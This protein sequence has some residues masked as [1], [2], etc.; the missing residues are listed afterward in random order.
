MAFFAS[1]TGMQ[2]EYHSAVPGD[3]SREYDMS[4][5]LNWMKEFLIL[6]LILTI[7]MHLAAAEEYKKYLRFLSG[8]ILLLV[9]ISP[10]LRLFGG[11][12]GLKI[13]RS[14]EGF[15]EKMDDFTSDAQRTA[16]LQDAHNIQ[17]YE[18]A[19]AAD[20]S[21]Q[22]REQGILVSQVSVSLS[23][24]YEINSVAVWLDA[25]Q[26][27]EDPSVKNRLAVLLQDTYHLEERQIFID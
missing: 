19:I 20:L 8:M 27:S 23:D 1:V 13:L 12:S 3:F 18:K 17:K 24:D 4:A 6:Y 21:A 15:W 14:Y 7:L 9:L 2:R 25:Q 11:D 22:V 10:A 5:I 26:K 16:F